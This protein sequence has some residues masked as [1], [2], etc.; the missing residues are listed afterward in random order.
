MY[1]NSFTENAY[2]NLNRSLKKT[3][4]KIKPKVFKIKPISCKKNVLYKSCRSVKHKKLFFKIN[5]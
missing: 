1:S 4:D 3:V 2:T 5:L